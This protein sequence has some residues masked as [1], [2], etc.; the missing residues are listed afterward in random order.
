MAGSL[1][2]ENNG[3]FNLYNPACLQY[4]EI[5]GCNPGDKIKVSDR[6]NMEKFISRKKTEWRIPAMQKAANWISFAAMIVML[7][8][9]IVQIILNITQRQDLKVG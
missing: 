8:T 6:E 4:P 9:I 1:L 2:R 7:L 5:N 3:V